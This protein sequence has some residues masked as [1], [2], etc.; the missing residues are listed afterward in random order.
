MSVRRMVAVVDDDE[1]VRLSITY[2]LGAAGHHVLSFASGDDFL[3]ARLPEHLDCVLLDLNMP[4]RSGIEVLDAL[5]G[6][7][8]APAVVVITG[9]GNVAL[10]VEAIKRGAI[11]FLEKPYAPTAL[12]AA[13]DAGCVLRDQPRAFEIAR[14]EA[15]ARLDV[16]SPRQRQVLAGIVGGRPNKIIAYQ[17]GLSIRTVEA[18]RAQLLQ[19]LGARGTAEVVRIGL[20]GG[21][22]MPKVQS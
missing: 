20:A 3:A 15:E 22:G 2:L 6:R 19:K 4:G 9:Q 17:L 18:Y 1:V 5:A 10:A 16:L 14:R 13:V 12:L 11:D 7:G 21:L 8:E